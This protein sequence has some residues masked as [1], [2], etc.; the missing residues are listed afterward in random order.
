MMSAAGSVFGN[1]GKVIGMPKGGLITGAKPLSENLSDKLGDLIREN[2]YGG[3]VSLIENE[4]GITIRILD[5]ILFPSG[6]AVISPGSKNILQEISE[7]IKELPNDIRIEGHTDNVPIHNS[8]YPSNW[9]LSVQRATNTAYFLMNQEGMF[10]EKI[11][12]VGYSEYKPVASNATVEGRELNR[13]V[14]IVILKDLN[15]KI[16]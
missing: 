5:D 16:E 9:H 15:N 7:V 13:R 11:S 8:E 3:S 1:Q 14:D 12:I 6:K 4:R 10:P 2:N